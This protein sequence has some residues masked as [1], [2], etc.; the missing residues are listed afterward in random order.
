MTFWP[1]RGSMSNDMS[2]LYR[3]Y[4]PQHFTDVLGQKHISDS[5]IAS[6][7][8]G[9]IGHAY[10]FSGPRGT[11]KT[12]LA[13]L[14]ARALNCP[15]RAKSGEPCGTC[16]LCREILEG[17]SVDVLEID[18]ASN[19]GIDEI[20]ELRERIAF[21]P[22][23]A[24]YKVYIIDE[25]HMLT[26]E[27]FNALLKTLEEPPAHAVFILATTELH[28]VPET[29]ISRCQRYAFHRASKEALSELL[30]AVAQKEKIAIDQSGLEALIDRAD[31][32]YRDALT[33]LGNLATHDGSLDGP[34]VRQLLGLPQ[35]EIVTTVLRQLLGGEVVE[36]SQALKRYIA[37]GLDLS[38]LVKAVADR[39][40][41]GIL[42]GTTEFPT[43]NLAAV[44][45][46]LLLTLA[47]AR[48]STDPSALMTAH[49]LSLALRYQATA[50]RG[51]PPAA[52]AM[53]DV[54][55]PPPVHDEVVKVDTVEAPAK[56][57][58]APPDDFWPHFLEG[59]KGHNHAL[60]MVVRSAALE[61]LS[62]DAVVIA[63]KFRFYVD[64]LTEIRNKK[65]IEAVAGEVAGRPVR[66]ECVIRADLNVVAPSDDLVRTVVDVFEV[67]ESK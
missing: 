38:A 4:R 52:P 18:A 3:Q 12:T 27:A 8:K 26:K 22:T 55:P 6:L 61:A 30:G 17:R 37:D 35:E 13:R 28:K 19:R 54:Q 56:L 65:I 21:A 39:C 40:K 67:E 2:S 9:R 32:S 58:V 50:A 60:Y 63:V 29:I 15:K 25:V 64:R 31:G 16:P 46:N 7:Q 33:L 51:V 59:I 36:L 47:R 45:E 5:L 44:L 34:T 42:G 41:D 62:E 14:Y 57:S 10:L 1:S 49:L 43:A 24:A 11:G 48:T 53:R 20:R 66:L 23:Q